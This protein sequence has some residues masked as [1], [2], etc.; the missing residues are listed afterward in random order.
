[1]RLFRLGHHTRFGKSGR[2]RE[3]RLARTRLLKGSPRRVFV[4]VGHRLDNGVTQRHP[5]LLTHLWHAGPPVHRRAG[6]RYPVDRSG[7][8]QTQRRHR[9]APSRVMSVRQAFKSTSALDSD[10]SRCAN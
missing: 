1:M 2:N 3:R 9:L 5:V 6:Q 8:M 10:A 7:R 4:G